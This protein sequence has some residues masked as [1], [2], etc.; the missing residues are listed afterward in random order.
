M[1][2]A[3]EEADLVIALLRNHPISGPVAFDWEMK[4]SSYRVYG[5]P[6][7]VVTAC[8]KAFCERIEDAGYEAMIYFSKYVGYYKLDLSQLRDYSIWYP[9]Y[10]T[11]A[12]TAAMLY[13]SFYYQVDVWQYSDAGSVNGISGPV[14]VN[15]W[16]V[17]VEDNT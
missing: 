6:P 2:E 4:D 17:P 16:L 13:P 15:L 10:R 12:N 7:E 14:D 9:E 11:T 8:A 1:E 3:I 5:T